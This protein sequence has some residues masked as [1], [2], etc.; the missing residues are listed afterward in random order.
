M[1]RAVPLACLLALLAAK[2]LV[3]WEAADHEPI[4]RA[5]PD[6]QPCP[7]PGDI[8]AP[9]APALCG[10]DDGPASTAPWQPAWGLAELRIFGAGPKVAPNG[11]TYHPSFSID[12]DFNLWLW[13]R[14]RLY[15]FGDFR[16]WGQRPENGVT[17]G[18]DGGL[19][20]SKRQ[21][22]LLGGP[23]W[24]YAGP[25][26]LRVYG[27]SMNN[28]NRGRDLATPYGVN[29]G[30]AVENRYYL[31]AE[32]DKLGQPG[33]DIT[34]ATFVS[35]GYLPTKE[36]VGNDGEKFKPGL[37][38][39]AYLTHDLGDWPAYA[40]GDA[41]FLTER[42]MHPKL[43]LFDLGVAVRP[44]RSWRQW[45]LR[46]GVENTADFELRSVLNLWYGSLRYVF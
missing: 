44:L 39:R 13:R 21:F 41:S 26:E 5:G 40:Y 28:L 10:L 8:G 1:V 18:R 31:S 38:L 22:D 33:Y 32:Y 12:L 19:G 27:Y 3:A 30:F 16:F 2:P 9:E 37:L 34:R 42:S 17:N 29:D 45:E 23:A 36:R 14:Q 46:L 7:V 11:E 15:L 20:F 25:W 24:N 4:A 6:C 35:I 43:L